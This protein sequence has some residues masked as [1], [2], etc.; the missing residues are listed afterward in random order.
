[1]KI[2][3]S[4]YLVGSG[5]AGF[6]LSEA[7]DCSVYLIDGDDSCCLIDSGSGI[8]PNLILDNIRRDGI[9]LDKV[10]SILL[11]H[12]HGDHAG[13][14]AAL[15]KALKAEVYAIS[16]VAGY[17]EQGNQKA[18]D[19][20]VAVST[21]LYPEGF[22]VKPVH[23]NSLKDGDIV[24]VGKATIHVILSLGHSAGHC[25]YLY[26]GNL[27]SGD[28]LT[29][30]GKIALQSLWDC[31]LQLYLETIRNLQKL[32]INGFYPGHGAFSVTRGKRHFDAAV[33]RMKKL[34]IPMNCI[35]E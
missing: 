12:G 33:E 9:S 8:A 2:T 11:T 26:D 10:K 21:G 1:M 13:G 32:D 35:G 17:I 20:D 24:R 31:D 22:E 28:V 14:A 5:D 29:A 3:D 34:W 4:I 25:C 23:V 15:G 18:L 27:F 6:S 7:A 19:V 16:E 30:D